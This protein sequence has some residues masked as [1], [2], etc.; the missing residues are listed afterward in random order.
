[1][2]SEARKPGTSR[3]QWLRRL[4]VRRKDR[5]AF[6]LSGGGPYGALQVGMLKALI[7]SGVKPD[8]VVGTSAG[9]MNA[10][11]VAIDPSLRGISRLESI[12]SSISDDDL[13]PGS[14][15]KRTWA[16][17]MMRGN[18]IFDNSG[19]RD[20]IERNL[21]ADIRFED[22]QLPLSIV[23]AELITGAETVFTS[24]RLVEPLLASAAMP[25]IWPPVEIDG[26]S[27]IDGGV[28]NSVPVGPALAAGASRLYVINCS[29]RR[30]ERRPLVRPMDHLLHAFMI[31]R[32]QRYELEREDIAA[33]AEL[34]D[35]PIP[36]LDFTVPFTSMSF[37]PQ[38]I[39]LGYE[40]ATRFLATLE[41]DASPKEAPAPG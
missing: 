6:V 34:I 4:A 33:K 16:R 3:A 37:T 5:T 23:A 18:R 15:N 19:L 35:I 11:F 24:G 22:T 10:A 40:S 20:L 9:A 17:L 27:Y 13:F 26:Q 29:A 7:E 31:S 30:Q 14:R 1:M 25:S 38:L 21:G 8:L 2:T 36:T 28:V 32:T 12:W 41:P 39:E